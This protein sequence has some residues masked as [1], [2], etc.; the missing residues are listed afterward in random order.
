MAVNDI[1]FRFKQNTFKP[2]KLITGY[3]LSNYIRNT[4]TD[5]KIKEWNEKDG[6][7]YNEDEIDILESNNVNA[8]IILK[9]EFVIPD[10]ARYIIIDPQS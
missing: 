5:N 6:Y 7:H 1:S 4:V 8:K 10:N 9:Y 3:C 2:P